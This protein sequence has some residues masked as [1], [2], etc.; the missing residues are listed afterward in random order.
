MDFNHYDIANFE[1]DDAE[2]PNLASFKVSKPSFLSQKQIFFNPKNVE[3]GSLRQCD[4]DL[5]ESTRDARKGMVLSL[6]HIHNIS[7]F[8][9]TLKK[10][11]GQD[12]RAR[13]RR[14]QRVLLGDDERI[15][16]QDTW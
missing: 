10:K 6:T 13:L 16:T 14:S 15:D 4:R 3:R 9:H 8:D 1:L 5:D 11:S 2:S 7:S 12:V